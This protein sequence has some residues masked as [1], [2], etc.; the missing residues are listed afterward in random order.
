MIISYYS[1]FFKGYIQLIK[2]TKTPGDVE[3]MVIIQ[4]GED[5]Q[6]KI[7]VY[8]SH[9]SLIHGERHGIQIDYPI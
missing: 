2:T 9:S 8:L 6:K 1:H 7:L 3:L 5:M 4:L